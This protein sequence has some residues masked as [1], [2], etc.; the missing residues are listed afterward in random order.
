MSASPAPRPSARRRRTTVNVPAIPPAKILPI[1]I[2]REIRGFAAH[3]AA[4]LAFTDW[5]VF[6]AALKDQNGQIDPLLKEVHNAIEDFMIERFWLELYPGAKKNFAATEIRCCRIYQDLYSKNPDIAKDLR[7]VGPVA[8]TWLRAIDFGLGTQVSRE[9]FQTMSV[10][11]Q[12]RVLKWFNDIQH[13][14]NT[15][16]CLDIARV[17]REDITKDPYDP[18]DPPQSMGGQGQGQGSNSKGAGAASG[19]GQQIPAS[20]P[21]IPTAPSLSDS[22][23]DADA[24]EPKKWIDVEALSTATSGSYAE[25]LADPEG[26][27]RAEEI[28]AEVRS[29]AAA[30]SSQLRRALRTAAK[31][32]WKGGRMDGK[33]DSTRLASVRIGAI[34]YHR[35]K[36]KGEDIDTALTV[37]VDCSG[38]MASSKGEIVICQQAAICL[39]NALHGTKVKHEIIGFTSGGETELDDYTK[40]V[41]EA[42][43][44]A[45]HR[46]R[47]PRGPDL[48]V[49]VVRAA[50]HGRPA[51]DREH[52]EC[53][54]ERDADLGR[55]ADGP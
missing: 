15:Q 45:G 12:Q 42:N 2:A 27:Q 52:G 35:R 33:I 5:D 21:P 30:V 7:V 51:H 43:Q 1:Q 29:H 46:H 16:D 32:R 8:L 14:E 31:S 3:E 11:L 18:Q 41:V 22:L 36:L 55:H 47:G 50:A 4:H 20:Q 23:K 19:A 9:C 25:V 13:V 44:G 28:T 54:H 24:V 39:E 10:S 40:T 17:I 37:L 34:D 26:Y 38:S 6:P 48:R 53:P 49:P